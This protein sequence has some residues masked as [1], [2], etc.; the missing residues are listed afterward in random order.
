MNTNKKLMPLVLVSVLLLMLTLTVAASA[1]EFDGEGSAENPYLI[2][3]AEQ[4]ADLAS[5]VN[6]G[7]TY[8][9]IYFLLTE[10]IDLGGEDN[11]WTPIG[12]DN[13]KFAGVFDGGEHKITGLY[14]N[15]TGD[16]YQGLFGYSSG[17][18]KNLTVNGSVNGSMYVGGIVGYSSGTIESCRFIGTVSSNTG[19]AGG[20]VGSSSGTI[21]GCYNA[22]DVSSEHEYA[23][24]IAGYSSS[25]STITNCL[26][27][28]TVSGGAHY[29]GG[30]VGYSNNGAITICHNT[31][32]V[33]DG[34]SV[35]GIVGYNYNGAIE[36]CCNTGTVSGGD[37]A[38][39]IAGNS[40]NDV[41]TNCY[42]T[43]YVSVKTNNGGSIAGRNTGTITNC[44]YLN[45]LVKDSCAA[46]ISTE[47]FAQEGTFT[48]WDFEGAWIMSSSLGRP[49]LR[50]ITGIEVSRLE[51]ATLSLESVNIEFIE[52]LVEESESGDAAVD[53]D[54]I[55][56][57]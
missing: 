20:I 9:D 56:E 34:D 1:A 37:Y 26:N 13:K 52:T 38:G 46:A 8:Q 22:G 14:F 18:I 3:S 48:G 32:Y 4:L 21:E 45:G 43:G 40:N 49:I 6:A 57:L 11:P 10:D 51:A 55:P 41:I 24:G 33:S 42:S 31:G 39:G 36:N 47:E 23:G 17:T 29:V 25:N 27:D 7:E 35:G 12:K 50:A 19:S 15:S 5:A 44:Y 30:I 54:F 28:G 16:Y 2:S 53:F